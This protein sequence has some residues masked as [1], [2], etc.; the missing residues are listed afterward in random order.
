M[1]ISNI[2]PV[3]YSLICARFPL[4]LERLSESCFRYCFEL[5]ILI[6]IV[7]SVILGLVDLFS[8]NVVIAHNKRCLNGNMFRRVRTFIF[9]SIN[10]IKYTQQLTKQITRNVQLS[11]GSLR[12]LVIIWR[13][14]FIFVCVYDW[15]VFFLNALSNCGLMRW[16][17]GNAIA[18]A[19]DLICLCKIS[20]QIDRLHQVKNCYDIR[21]DRYLCY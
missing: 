19:L 2:Y 21:F 17:Y 1:N 11:L 8:R 18:F 3:F 20:A 6:G 5:I 7:W 10:I 4:S 13:M 15:A 12:V 9:P 14:F 16:I